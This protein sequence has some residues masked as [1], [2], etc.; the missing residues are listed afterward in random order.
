MQWL[1]FTTGGASGFGTLDGEQVRVHRGELFG[2]N[3][4]TGETIPLAGL[5]WQTPC[6]PSKMIALLNN[7]HAGLKKQN[8]P[9]PTEPLFFI[10]APNTFCAHGA[11]IPAP[12]AYT[13]RVLWEGELG[14]VIGK[15]GRDIPLE[16]AG[17]YVFGYTCVNDLTAF[18]LFAADP[19]HEQW[20]R[21]KGFDGFGPFG[22]VIATGIDPAGLVIRTLVNGRERQNYPVAD[23]VFAPAQLVSLISRDLTLDYNDFV[24]KG[25]LSSLQIKDAKPCP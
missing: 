25:K 18:D 13:G 22:P 3:E 7:F 21:A 8:K 23:M 15:R 5:T 14:I 20:T 10:K 24:V 1:R 9:A 2:A 6:A 17:E 12:R 19:N 11:T 4:P 16:S